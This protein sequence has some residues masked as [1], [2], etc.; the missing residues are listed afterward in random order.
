MYCLWALM[1]IFYIKIN[2]IFWLL[3]T[4]VWIIKIIKIKYFYPPRILTNTDASILVYNYRPER[5]WFQYVRREYAT[6]INFPYITTLI[7]TKL[8]T[9][10]CFNRVPRSKFQVFLSYNRIAK[11]TN[12][13]RLL[14]NIYFISSFYFFYLL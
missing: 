2:K 14:L 12:K 5:T 1:S 4:F 10:T 6:A 8:R 11:Q 7:I 9:F 13:R 3:E